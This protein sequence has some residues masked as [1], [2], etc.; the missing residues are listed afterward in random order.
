MPSKKWDERPI[1]VVVPADGAD[2][3]LESINEFLAPNFAK[4][5]L[6]DELVIV[7]DIPKTSVGKIDKK[8]IR[9]DLAGMELA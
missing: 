4:W 1:A 2:P 3:T 7:D 6:P 9:A 8:K 5:W